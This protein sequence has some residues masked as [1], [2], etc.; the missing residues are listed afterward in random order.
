MSGAKAGVVVGAVGK[1]R[2]CPWGSPAPT[3][4]FRFRYLS[5]TVEKQ[6]GKVLL[7]VLSQRL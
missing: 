5:A 7:L 4:V 3:Q 6:F 1:G 2:A